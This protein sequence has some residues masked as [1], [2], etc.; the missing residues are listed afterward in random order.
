[1]AMKDSPDIVANQFA[2]G[3]I[4]QTEAIRAGDHRRGNR[5]A[6]QYV[7]A[8][9]ELRKLGDEGR[10]ALVPLLQHERIDVRVMAACFLLRYRTP[11]AIAVLEAAS[12]AP[13]ISALGAAETLKR[14][15]NGSWNLD[16]PE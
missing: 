16:P 14:W 1:M 13:S 10:E 9:Q 3:V 2:Q 4:G 6:K 11:E 5:Y 8:F 15:R 7:R 12:K